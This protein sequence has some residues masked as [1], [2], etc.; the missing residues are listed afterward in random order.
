[1]KTEDIREPIEVIALFRSGNLCPLK[2]RWKDHI[3]KV[4]RVNGNWSTDEG[5]AHYHHFAVMSDGPDVFELAYNEHDF[6]WTLER[7][8]LIG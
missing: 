7:V 4:C 2:F 5:S 3:Y 6:N 1:M 8:S